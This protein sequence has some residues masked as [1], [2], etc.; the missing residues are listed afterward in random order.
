M[1]LK[2]Y[3][4]LT[5]QKEAFE[6][7]VKGKVGMYLCGPTVYDHAHLGHGRSAVAFDVV[8]RYLEYVYGEKNVTFVT[9]YTDIDDKMINR[10][11]EEGITVKALAQK[12]IPEYEADYDALG[13][14]RPTVQTKATDKK[15]IDAMI[16]LVA[17]L[18]EKRHAYELADGVYFDIST[19]PEYGKLSGQKQKELQAGARVETDDR[20]RHPHDFVLWKFKKEGESKDD[21]TAWDSPWGEGRPGWHIE[22]SA[23]S[24]SELGQPFDIHAGG[25][26]LTFPHHEC[27]IAQSEAAYGMQFC[28]VWLHNGFITVNKEKMS[29]SLGN[30]STLKD[31]FQKYD[32]RVVRYFYLTMHYRSP[33]EFTDDQLQQAK[34]A[35]DRIRDFL[36]RLEHYQASPSNPHRELTEKIEKFIE[37][38]ESAM[39]EDF[40]TPSALAALFE[41]IKHLH[42]DMDETALGTDDKKSILRALKKFDAVLHILPIA[43]KNLSSKE[44]TLIQ[45]REQARKEKNW[46][47]SDELREAL[48]QKG[49]LVED[50]PSGTIWKRK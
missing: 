27:E 47:R 3:N 14:K 11:G 8:R 1:A 30:F 19:F 18:I 22:C 21:G 50:T 42:K 41:F 20:K 28:K 32:P 13:I 40:D 6:P 9:N 44:T 26:D 15:Y 31:I 34:N 2:V 24:K 23:M 48:L 38:F 43:E 39:N 33:I 35:L 4:T 16:A 12:I 25:M 7:V 49:I 5:R 17:T 46:K 29:K 45:E 36:L 37:G 10:A